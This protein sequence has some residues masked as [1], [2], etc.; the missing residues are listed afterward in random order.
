MGTV[1]NGQV[2]VDAGKDVEVTLQFSGVDIYSQTSSPLL[3]RS[4]KVSLELVEGS[5]NILGDGSY[6]EH[7]EENAAIY[8]EEDLSIHGSGKLVI[9][10]NAN[11]AITT[12]S[13]LTLKAGD[14]TLNATDDGIRGKKG[15]IID[16]GTLKIIAGGDALKSDHEEYG[17]ILINGGDITLQ[18]GGDGVQA[19]KSIT[20]NN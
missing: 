4:G 16:G 19:Y 10:A 2:I 18:A 12:K 8:A 5:T 6:D 3:I 13:L 14:I 17:N 9:N 11:D 20:F 1:K 15:L 7:A